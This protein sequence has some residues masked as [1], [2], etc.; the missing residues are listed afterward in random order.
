M[1]EQTIHP[2]DKNNTRD[3]HLLHI[4]ELSKKIR[5]SY[6]DNAIAIEMII[7]DI[8]SNHF[9]P[10]EEKRSL[11]FTLVLNNSGFNLSNKI[12]MLKNILNLKYHDLFENHPTLFD[13]LN[14]IRIFRNK[15]AHSFLDT[16]EEYLS[17]NVTNQIQLEYFK[18]GQKLH[19]EI[20]LSEINDKLA[21]NS[22]TIIELVAIQKEIIDRNK[23]A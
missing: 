7:A 10:N 21:E 16:S 8:I 5:G 3:Q 11:F 18:N 15:L 23:I 9:C 22:K 1:E 4:F 12:N 14:N 19:Q 2:F 20:T 13:K 17:K 6:L